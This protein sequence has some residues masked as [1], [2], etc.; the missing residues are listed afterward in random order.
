MWMYGGSECQSEVPVKLN[1]LK[2]MHFDRMPVFI[3]QFLRISYFRKLF[4]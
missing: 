4:L 3:L 1:D 2:Y